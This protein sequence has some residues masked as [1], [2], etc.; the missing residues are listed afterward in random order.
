M[1]VIR[2]Q[3][4]LDTTGGTLAPSWSEATLTGSYLLAVMAAT[5]ANPT[6]EPSGW[7]LLASQVSAFGGNW[8]NAYVIPNAASQSGSS[9]WTF[10]ASVYPGIVLVELTG[11]PSRT[12][13]DVTLDNG[14]AT[15]S[16]SSTMTVNAL[17]P[18]VYQDVVFVAITNNAISTATNALSGGGFSLVANACV[19]GDCG[20][21]LGWQDGLAA[22]STLNSGGASVSWTPNHGTNTF[23]DAFQFTIVER[24]GT[25]LLYEGKT[26]V[27]R[28]SLR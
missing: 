25:P 14:V 12:I 7:Q 19:N 27:Q 3:V 17:G 26:A 15:T 18:T 16:T 4:A 13:T 28:A 23:A 21:I 11:M 9:S 8:Y 20:L 2:Q 5:S 22:T 1:A 6:G 10:G 24:L